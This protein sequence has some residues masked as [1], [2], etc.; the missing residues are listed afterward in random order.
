[1]ARNCSKGEFGANYQT[2]KNLIFAEKLD[3][4]FLKSR[5]NKY[6][7]RVKYDLETATEFALNRPDILEEDKITLGGFLTVIK[8]ATHSPSL[9]EGLELGK[10]LLEKYIPNSS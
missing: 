10:S 9:I 7:S 5:H 6:L 2:M 4:N 1:M 8:A 3:S